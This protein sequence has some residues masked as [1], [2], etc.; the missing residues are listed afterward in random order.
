MMAFSIG[1]AYTDP[2]IR[3]SSRLHPVCHPSCRTVTIPSLPDKFDIPPK[4]GKEKYNNP[5]GIE[6][7][8]RA[9]PRC[10]R[11][12]KAYMQNAYRN[13]EQYEPPTHMATLAP[14]FHRH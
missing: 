11:K 1:V 14:G 7:S 4:H 5:R 6:T 13:L 3:L 10:E 2:M 9:R 12:D 8:L